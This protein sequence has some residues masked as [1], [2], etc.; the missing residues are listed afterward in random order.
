MDT[1]LTHADRAAKTTLICNAYPNEEAGAGNVD[2]FISFIDFVTVV[3]TGGELMIDRYLKGAE[4][5]D[6]FD[7][8]RSFLAETKTLVP[9][10]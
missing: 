3:Q 1:W 6:S 8:M 10:V 9:K 2:S 5:L 7:K 4:W